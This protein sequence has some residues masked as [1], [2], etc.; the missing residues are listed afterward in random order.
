MNIN[1]FVNDNKM[2]KYLVNTVKKELLFEKKENFCIHASLD[3]L[4]YYIKDSSLKRGNDFIKE[5]NGLVKECRQ[6]GNGI[7]LSG[8]QAALDLMLE[9]LSSHY[10]SF[11]VSD[12]D[13]D[14]NK[15]S[16]FLE[17]EDMFIIEENILNVLRTLHIADS[18]SAIED[19][20]KSYHDSHNVKIVFLV[21]SICFCS[22]IIMVMILVIIIKFSF[23]INIISEI[24]RVFEKA[25]QHYN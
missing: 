19:V 21:V 11:K 6:L 10:Y 22:G 9:L 2:K 1:L 25:I 18:Y 23:Y 4:Q 8:Y 24:G 3:Y 16:A 5:W 20:E 17:S 7:N 13:D 14:V 15:Q 12:D